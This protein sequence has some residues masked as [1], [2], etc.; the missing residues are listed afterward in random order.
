[1]LPGQMLDDRYL[2]EAEAGTGGMGTVWR[3]QDTRI[4]RTVAIKVLHSHLAKDD[5]LR[6]RFDREA[7]L[8]G[9]LQHPGV[10]QLYDFTDTVV[11]GKSVAYLVME[12]VPGSSLAT[13]LPQRMP[14]ERTLSLV[15]SAAEGLHSAHL[16]GIVHR[17]VKPA[18]ILVAPDDTAKIVDFGISQSFGDR[19]L[20]MTGHFMGSLHY[21]SPEQLQGKPLT[22]ASDVYS[23]GVVAY[24]ALTGD[25]PFPGDTPASVLTGH[26][27]EEPRPLPADV[28][29]P[30]AALVMRALAKEPEDRFES[31]AALATACRRL[32]A[33]TEITSQTPIPTTI[34]PT[35]KTSPTTMYPAAM[36]E[37][38]P[39]GGRRRSRLLPVTIIVLVLLLATG[40]GAAVWY[41]A[42]GGQAALN[43]DNVGLANL[44]DLKPVGEPIPFAEAGASDRGTVPEPV[45]DGETGYFVHNV[46][47]AP[48]T[49]AVDL[50]SGKE[51]WR[52]PMD[53]P[54]GLAM[55]AGQGL[56]YTAD[57]EQGIVNFLD[58]ATGESLNT[59][60]FDGRIGVSTFGSRVLIAPEGDDTVTAYEADG[61]EAWEQSFEE[62]VTDVDIEAKWKDFTNQPGRYSSQKP[63]RLLIYGDDGTVSRLDTEDGD[64]LTTT[65]PD[66]DL[67]VTSAFQGMMFTADP[68]DEDG[69]TLIAHD[70]SRDFA[71][72]G[73]WEEL[74]PG[75][76]PEKIE[77]C[78]KTRICV[79]DRQ[80]SGTTGAVV[81]DFS[82]PGSEPLWESSPETP[83]NEIY[84]AGST[85]AVVQ[86]EGANLSTQLYDNAMEPR[87]RAKN[88]V[89]RPVD[90]KTFLDYPRT[91]GNAPANPV[92][93]HFFTGLDATDGSTKDLGTQ[94]V[95]PQCVTEGAHVACPTPKG[96]TVWEYRDAR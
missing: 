9:A 8:I 34:R 61:A 17:D 77:W 21:V 22:P 53:Q 1:M 10:V 75:F 82:E 93:K 83:V 59:A 73:R 18:N 68:D 50:D 86:G 76:N 43:G 84:A 20:T 29:A 3:A 66:S 27:Q 85:V 51:K 89:F 30:V 44:H 65:E 31:A 6:A 38:T 36:P 12:Y 81:L 52:Q 64:I 94:E 5:K 48:E 32:S 60:E 47:E 78:G 41:Y 15:A 69:Y 70:V 33:D 95:F 11:D 79:K 88:G 45:T 91:A 28:P 57:L 55:R 87:G 4:G 2:L 39:V 25:L 23:L 35:V 49:I 56:L 13:E 40:G 7:R 46:A 37:P 72:V 80:Y 67:T 62:T 26:L 16:R 14:V 54:I 74:R 90:G 19:K 42:G 58:P 63:E 96:I 71:E 92:N 24:E